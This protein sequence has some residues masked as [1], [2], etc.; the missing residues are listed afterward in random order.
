MPVE[1]IATAPPTAAP[2]RSSGAFTVSQASPAD[3][4]IADATPCTKR[5][6]PSTSALGANANA[7]VAAANTTLPK[8]I[9]ARP[10]IR[11]DSSPAGSAPS[12][13]AAG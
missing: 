13:P 5:A 1:T 11:D 7:S 12:T 6:R 10:P 8:I 2:R 9:S 4:Q 3:Q